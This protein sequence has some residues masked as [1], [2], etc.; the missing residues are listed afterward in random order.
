MFADVIEA[1]SSH[2]PYRPALEMATAKAEILDK[3]GSAYCSECVDACIQL[4]E[5]Q[6]DDSQRLFTFL[7]TQDP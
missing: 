3:R 1:M 5:S 7:E 6:N 2:R 4:I